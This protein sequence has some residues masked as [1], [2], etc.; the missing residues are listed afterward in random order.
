[1]NEYLMIGEVLKPQGIRGEVKVKPFSANHDDFR[2]WKTLYIRKG[3]GYEAIKAKC[4]R[5]HDGF[6]YVTLGECASMEDAEKLRGVQLWID[7]AHAN[8]LEE[9]E[10]YI[11]DLIGCEG[12]DEEGKSIGVLSDVLQH[13]VVD[14]YVFKQKSRSVMAPA[15]KAVFPAVDVAAKR[16]SV[17]RERLDE[18]AVWED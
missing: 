5:V 13:G 18:V 12:V 3:E 15:L 16:I 7:R 2:R 11:S 4:S 14:V 6:V 8:Q 1:M 10:V 9:D 17:V